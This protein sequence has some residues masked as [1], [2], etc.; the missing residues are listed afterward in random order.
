MNPLVVLGPTASGKSEVAMAVAATG[1]WEIVAVDAMQVYRGMD[2]GTAK[3][4]AAD[5]ALVPHHCLDLVEPWD[6]FSVTD[7]V[8]AAQAAL[9]EIRRRGSR[10]LLVAGTGLYLRAITDPLDIPGQWPA[11]RA[12]LER[13]AREESVAALHAELTARDPLAASRIE[14]AN[15]RRIVRA[16]E[17]TLGSGRP[18]SSYGPGLDNY[19]PVPF[20]QVG[21]RWPRSDL[22]RRIEHR[23][24]TM[25]Q[26]G[27]LDEVRALAGHP[28]GM[29]RT[30]RQA[31][32]YKELLDHLAGRWTLDEAVAA[33]VLRTR[34]FAVRQERWFRRDPRIRWV[35]ITADP[36]AEVLAAL[37]AIDRAAP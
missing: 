19:P 10:P 26:A 21:M 24:R 14:P 18:F 34:Q 29:S 36:V 30:A 15:A 37:P 7:F 1:G 12:E 13:R 28:H 22:G 6:D 35:E 4:T 23:V 2:I 17:V 5:R 3:P 31:L 11:L 25:M 27:L 8:A 32:G 33:I 9:D 20:V 16:L